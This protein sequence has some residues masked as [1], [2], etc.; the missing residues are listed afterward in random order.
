M[1]GH[2]A[3]TEKSSPS[4]D[5][6]RTS[7]HTEISSPEPT[8]IPLPNTPPS[9]PESGI[10][11]FSLEIPQTILS[12]A[13]A[14]SA[15]LKTPQKRRGA[16]EK[17]VNM[18]I[19]QAGGEPLVGISATAIPLPPSPEAGTDMTSLEVVEKSQNPALLNGPNASSSPH[20][21]PGSGK[22]A[23]RRS[24]EVSP[25]SPTP[26]QHLGNKSIK[27][28]AP[29]NKENSAL[30]RPKQAATGQSGLM[31]TDL[32]QWPVL[33]EVQNGTKQKRGVSVSQSMASPPRRD[34]AVSVV[35]TTPP[36]NRR[37]Q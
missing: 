31:L 10:P 18:S 37:Q 11:V 20:R 17:G 34:S 30:A 16:D 19:R 21:G 26:K 32:N 35:A 7:S 5:G 29:N 1:T 3:V 33:G 15:E 4:F 27:R 25:D 24:A 28:N 13:P 23:K 14:A 22:K 9:S 8:D 2:S 12:N 6:A 36:R